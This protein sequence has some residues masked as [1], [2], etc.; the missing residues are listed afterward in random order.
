[1]CSYLKLQLAV[2]RRIH[3]RERRARCRQRLRISDSAGGSENPQELITLPVDAAEQA[4][5]LEDHA[6]RND[7][8]K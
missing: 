6:P 5:L 4:K 8:E 3:I 1:M 2:S 7:G